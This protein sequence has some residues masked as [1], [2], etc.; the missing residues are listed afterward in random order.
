[1]AKREY[2]V[3]PDRPRTHL[4]LS[5]M[6]IGK[7]TVLNQ[8]PTTKAKYMVKCDC[9]RRETMIGRNI[10]RRKFPMC[11]ECFKLAKSNNGW[12]QHTPEVNYAK[13]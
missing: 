3:R 5:G 13:H 9:G 7:L 11:S 12:N 1:M 4:D 6:R 2:Y 8:S 10:R